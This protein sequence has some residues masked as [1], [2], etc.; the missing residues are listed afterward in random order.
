[1]YTNAV[2]SSLEVIAFLSKKWL[3]KPVVAFVI[4]CCA[5]C[6]EACSLLSKARS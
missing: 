5:L 1:M 6:L 4:F 2:H 3:K